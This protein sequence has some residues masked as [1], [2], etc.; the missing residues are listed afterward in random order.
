MGNILLSNFKRDRQRERERSLQIAIQICNFHVRRI[1][2][3]S[4]KG[5]CI[6]L[7]IIPKDRKIVISVHTQ[8]MPRI[9][10]RFTCIGDKTSHRAV[11]RL[12]A[13]RKHVLDFAVLSRARLRYSKIVDTRTSRFASVRRAEKERALHVLDVRVDP[14][15]DLKATT[16][17][18]GLAACIR[19]PATHPR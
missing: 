4:A 9:V 18:R 5:Y 8:S 15:A 7:A 14:L 2:L 3:R 13:S 1:Y 6:I 12:R 17:R 16:P 11:F 19:H 10:T